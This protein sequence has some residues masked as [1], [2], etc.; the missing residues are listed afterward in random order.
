MS[1]IEHKTHKAAAVDFLQ[2]VVAGNIDQAYEKYVDMDGKH[3]NAFFPAGFPALKKA[4]A[5]AHLQFPNKVF[6]TKHVLGDN[7]MVAVHSCMVLKPG[8]MELG[9]LHLFRFKDGKIVEMWDL[10]QQVPK[11]LP[12]QDGMF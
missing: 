2:M 11:D 5:E 4:M 3:H 7:D 9:V 1:M 6:Q 8:E 12:N 10:G